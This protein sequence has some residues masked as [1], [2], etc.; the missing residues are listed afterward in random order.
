MQ[1]RTTLL[2]LTVVVAMTATAAGLYLLHR[3]HHPRDAAP[4]EATFEFMRLPFA[5]PCS[6]STADVSLFYAALRRHDRAEVTKMF[7]TDR[8]HMIP[9]GTSLSIHNGSLFATV[10]VEDHKQAPTNCFIPGDVVPAIER[11]AYK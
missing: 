1:A 10:T 7:E 5:L 8:I 11:K 3:L 2:L 4:A 9:K 6:M